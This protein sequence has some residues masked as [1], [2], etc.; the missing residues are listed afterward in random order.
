[1]RVPTN[2]SSIDGQVTDRSV[3]SNILNINQF[4]QNLFTARSKSVMSRAQPSKNEVFNDRMKNSRIHFEL[5]LPH[6]RSYLINMASAQNTV[7]NKPLC[8]ER[9]D[10]KSF[11]KPKLTD[12]A[13][14]QASKVGKKMKYYEPKIAAR[15]EN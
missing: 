15:P 12:I 6:S 5:N 7:V 1:M 11:I 14:I 10:V 2:L 4:E 3:V 8:T 9:Q 13:R